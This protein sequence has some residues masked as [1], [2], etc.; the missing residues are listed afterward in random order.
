MDLDAGK[1][2]RI[3]AVIVE[4]KEGSVSLSTLSGRNAAAPD[5]IIRG[6]TSKTNGALFR[7]EY[8][9]RGDAGV[10]ERTREGGDWN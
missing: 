5:K 2:Y 7:I 3:S 9:V 10:L 6:T 4:L 1:L 8:G